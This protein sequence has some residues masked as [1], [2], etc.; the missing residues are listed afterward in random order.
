MRRDVV[1]VGAGLAGLSAARD[2]ATSGTDVVVLEARGR[3][4]GRVEQTRLPDGRVVQLGGELVGEFHT[5][6]RGLADELGLTVIPGFGNLSSRGEDVYLLR[7]ERVVGES[8]SWL[9]DSDRA[10][11]DAAEAEFV[12]AMRDALAAGVTVTEV[13]ELTGYHRNSVRRIVDAQD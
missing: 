13:A 2:L 12:A 9:T 10:S 7:E 6:Y 8:W 4:G 5:A 11:Y 1:V 3:P